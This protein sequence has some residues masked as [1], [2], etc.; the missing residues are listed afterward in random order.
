MQSFPPICQNRRHEI[1]KDA[2]L[3]IQ[4]ELSL[5][6]AQV[7]LSCYMQMWV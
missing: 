6:L 1:L 7:C 2:D 4:T 3:P 5:T